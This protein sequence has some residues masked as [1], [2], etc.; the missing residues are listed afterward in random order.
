MTIARAEPRCPSRSRRTRFTLLTVNA[1]TVINAPT[2]SQPRTGPT[3][4][5]AVLDRS[6]EATIKCISQIHPMEAL[7]HRLDP[8]DVVSFLAGPAGVVNGQSIYVD[9][10]AI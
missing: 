4:T 1:P 10:G 5:A 8:A 6:D 7:A 9:D 3:A 2:A